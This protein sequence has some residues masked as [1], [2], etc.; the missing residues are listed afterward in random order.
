MSNLQRYDS[1]DEA[2]NPTVPY[3]KSGEIKW[4]TPTPGDYNDGHYG[5][6]G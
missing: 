2:N 3:I 4:G 5:S 6:N 1:T